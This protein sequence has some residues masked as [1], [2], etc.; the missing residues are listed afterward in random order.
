MKRPA[1]IIRGQPDKE[2]ISARCLN[3]TQSSSRLRSRMEIKTTSFYDKK[4]RDTPSR[5]RSIESYRSPQ[6]ASNKSKSPKPLTARNFNYSRGNSQ[7]PT[8]KPQKIVR[9]NIVCI[10]SPGKQDV[11]LQLTMMYTNQPL[12]TKYTREYENSASRMVVKPATKT[13]QV[14]K[15]KVPP[16]VLRNI[17]QP[18][19]QNG[20]HYVGTTARI[21]KENNPI[22]KAKLESQ[23]LLKRNGPNSARYDL[24]RSELRTR[25]NHYK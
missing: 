14:F 1:K 25:L 10:T 12:Q 23:M 18:Q 16:I 15:Q 3:Q 22:A 6:H 8:K 13:P 24:D 7:T 20:L 17:S 9:E 2:N 21:K 5:D 19:G 4:V 11:P